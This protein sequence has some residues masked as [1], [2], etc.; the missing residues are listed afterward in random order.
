MIEKR[1]SDAGLED[2]YDR[3]AEAIDATAEDKRMLFLAKATLMLAN[4]VGDPQLVAEA[5]AAAQRDL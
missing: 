4:L 1:M 5:I 2:V 3:V